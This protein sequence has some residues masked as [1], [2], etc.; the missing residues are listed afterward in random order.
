M[1]L[2][3]KPPKHH[4]EILFWGNCERWSIMEQNEWGSK[5][6]DKIKKEMYILWAGV[7]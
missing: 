6:E 5:E 7:K 4:G 3:W 2:N 1:V